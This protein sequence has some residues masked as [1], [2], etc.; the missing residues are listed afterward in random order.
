[1]YKSGICNTKPVVSLKRSSLEP[2]LLQT[3]YRNL[4]T[5]LCIDWWQVWWSKA[6]FGLLF[7][8]AKFFRKGYLAHFLSER[9]KSWQRWGSAQSKLIRRI[10]W[11]VVLVIP[12][13]DTY[14]SFTDALV[15]WFFDNFP[16]YR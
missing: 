15:K 3:V 6:N 14:Q 8:G 5:R 11:T 7:R 1:M 4:C 10:S 2:K 9:D 12:C 13:R 16:I